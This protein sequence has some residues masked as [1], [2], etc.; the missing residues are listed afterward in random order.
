MYSWFVNSNMEVQVYEGYVNPHLMYDFTSEDKAREHV[1]E[2]NTT[3][4][5]GHRVKWHLENGKDRALKDLYPRVKY[6]IS[7]QYAETFFKAIGE[8]LFEYLPFSFGITDVNVSDL[9]D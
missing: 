2:P 1:I 8:D 4:V 7:K 5:D 9:L 6:Y 3:V